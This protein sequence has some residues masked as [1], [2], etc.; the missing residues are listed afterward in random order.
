MDVR[1]NESERAKFCSIRR[2][3]L[4]AV[5]DNV[6]ARFPALPL[7]AAMSILDPHNLPSNVVDVGSYGDTKLDTLLDH[8]GCL[9]VIWHPQLIRRMPKLSGCC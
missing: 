6:R 5:I 9:N 7:F 8:F 1:D 2:Q 4:Q 3:F